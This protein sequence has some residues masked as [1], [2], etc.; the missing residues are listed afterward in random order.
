MIRFAT[1]IALLLGGVCL[2]VL[3]LELPASLFERSWLLSDEPRQADASQE[4][5][6][7]NSHHG[8]PHCFE[9]TGAQYTGGIP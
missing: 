7:K 8:S 2:P 6:E 4:K 1:P 9:F 3:L 5:K